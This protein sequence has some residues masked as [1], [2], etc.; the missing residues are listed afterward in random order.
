MT[1][2]LGCWGRERK[3]FG[4][5]DAKKP[6]IKSKPIFKIHLN[7]KNHYFFTCPSPRIWWGCMLAQEGEEGHLE[8]AIYYLSKR[9]TRYELNYSPLKK[10]YWALVWCARRLRYCMLAFQI[11]LISRMD[12]LKYIFEKP[13]LASRIS[14]WTL[15]LAEFDIKYV[16]IKAI[17]CRA[18]A[19]YLSNLAVG[20]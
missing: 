4:I 19:E 7:L 20:F 14:Q 9:M 11:V 15:M 18:V 3:L 16:I 17:K 2:F 10:T 1:H 13:A 8:K 6:S 5:T 12:P